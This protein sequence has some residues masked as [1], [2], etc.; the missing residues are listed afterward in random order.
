MAAQILRMNGDLDSLGRRWIYHFMERNPLVAS[1]IGRKLQAERAEAATPEQV[2][3]FYDLF[4]RVRK[5]FSIRVED[6]WNIDETGVAL[7]VCANTRVLASSRKNKAYVK[8]PED[9]EWVSIVET[10]SASGQKIQ[11]LVISKGK[12]LQTP[13]FP[14]QSIPEWFYTTSENG[15]TSNA[16][17]LEWPKDI[18][19]PHFHLT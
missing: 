11:L 2:Q 3:A 5:R 9:R 15:W 18:F 10:V 13:W 19:I 7:G 12:S 1:V 4:E 16:I 17:G 6:T 14:S 8:S